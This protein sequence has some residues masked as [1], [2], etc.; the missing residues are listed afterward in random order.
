M[1][2]SLGIRGKVK[3]DIEQ[4]KKDLKRWKKSL[5]ELPEDAPEEVVKT[6][7]KR[8]A[9][10]IRFVLCRGDNYWQRFYDPASDRMLDKKIR[11]LEDAYLGRLGKEDAD[12][13]NSI[14]EKKPKDGE[15][16]II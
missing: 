1:R 15:M 7:K 6:E 3:M 2:N 14:L 16:V 5:S 9:N 8:Y 4:K 12:K 10:T 13:I 11:I